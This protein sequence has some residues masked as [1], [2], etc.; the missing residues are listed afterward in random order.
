IAERLQNQAE[1]FGFTVVDP[2]TVAATHLTELLRLVTPELLGRSEAQELIDLVAQDEPRLVDELIPNLL[3]LG[4]VI[5]VL[6]NLLAEGV[7]IRDLRSILEALADYARDLKDP[8]QLT[9]LVRQRLAR[10]ITA[11]FRAEDGTVA[12]IVLA[13]MAEQHF[14]NLPIPADVQQRLLGSLNQAASSFATVTTPPL[15]LCAA[16]VRR[17]VAAFF[18]SRVPGLSVASYAEIDGKTTVRTL[19]HVSG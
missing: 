2:A 17:P 10:T 18:G 11:R 6:R 8:D 1:A 12:A 14:R 19:A 16:D 13:P 3:P 9:E 4:E 5:K 15:V 7:S